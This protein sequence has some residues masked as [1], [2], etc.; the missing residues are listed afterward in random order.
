ERN[1]RAEAEQVAQQGARGA[2]LV[3]EEDRDADE[4]DDDA[5]PGTQRWTLAQGRKQCDREQRHGA[6]QQRARKRRRALEP[7]D[8]A[9]LIQTISTHASDSESGQIRALDL[10][11]RLAGGKD[12]E[13]QR[14]DPN[15]ADKGERERRDLG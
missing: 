11:T 1:R 5:N 7:E 15:K 8:E 13:R 2:D 9:Q 10:P 6:N 14:R 12:D 4:R 3:G